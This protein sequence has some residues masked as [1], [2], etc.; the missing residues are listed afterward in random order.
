MPTIRHQSQTRLHVP[1]LDDAHP[2]GQSAMGGDGWIQTICLLALE[3][4]T[5][6]HDFVGVAENLKK[7]FKIQQKTLT[8]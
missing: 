5:G 7:I 4:T 8:H 2:F 6:A 1:I 3:Q